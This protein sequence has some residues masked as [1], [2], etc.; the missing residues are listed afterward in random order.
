MNIFFKT[1][2]ISLSLFVFHVILIILISPFYQKHGTI[3]YGIM[4]S[5]VYLFIVASWAYFLLMLFYVSLSRGKH[6]RMKFLISLVI[7]LIG[8]V[9]SRGGDII[10]GDFIKNFSLIILL[11]FIVSAPII[12]GIDKLLD[13]K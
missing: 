4:G 10:D 13:K 7:M 3:N 12:V 11:G 2:I 8:Y 1:L 9:I 6:I 5:A